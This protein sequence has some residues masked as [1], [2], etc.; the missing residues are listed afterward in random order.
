MKCTDETHSPECRKA[1][2]SALSR[3]SA[4]GHF[5]QR[6]LPGD[7]SEDS[8]FGLPHP[9]RPVPVRILPEE[10]PAPG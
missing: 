3:S 5:K 10:P 9:L 4:D 2:E 8:I 7:S 1:L 6:Y